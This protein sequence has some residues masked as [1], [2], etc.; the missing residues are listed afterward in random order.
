M[1]YINLCIPILAYRRQQLF[2]LCT[3]GQHAECAASLL[4]RFFG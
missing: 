2:D 3:V 1:A 4:D